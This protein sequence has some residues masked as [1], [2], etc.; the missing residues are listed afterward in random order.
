MGVAMKRLNRRQA[1]RKRCLECSG[2]SPKE[3]KNC[4]F[5]NCLLYPYRLGFGYQEPKKRDKAIRD[6]CRQDCMN[7]QNYE[8]RMCPSGNCPLFH[9]RQT[10]NTSTDSKKT[11]PAGKFKAKKLRVI[12][13]HGK[14]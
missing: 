3:V 4:T 13:E 8:V 10:R 6:Y 5:N 1:I 12:S 14:E 2:F 7:N 9:F 11:S